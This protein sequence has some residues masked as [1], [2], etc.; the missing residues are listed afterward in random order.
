MKSQ[1]KLS[2]YGFS[3][4]ELLVCMAV[5]AILSSFALPSF[6]QIRAQQEFKSIQS[7]LQQQINSA[8]SHALT[9]Q[10]D[11]V[12]CAAPDMHT[13]ANAQWQQGMLL[14]IDQNQNR[15]LD[16]GETV[17]SYSPTQLKYGNLSWHGNAT[18][19]H[20]IVFQSD[21]GLPRG[22]Q[23]SFRYCSQYPALNHDFQLGG[24]GHLGTIASTQCP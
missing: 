22:S 18:H 19:P 3:L 15:K 24:M 4:I 8:R 14:Y 21:H 2:R 12:I 7:L 9:V 6:Q 13:C 11:I 23:G 20:Q 16:V 1:L 5:I 17:L 10:Q